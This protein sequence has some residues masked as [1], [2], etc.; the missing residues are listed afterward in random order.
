MAHATRAWETDGGAVLGRRF[1]AVA[2]AD[3]VPLPD[4]GLYLTVRIQ[5]VSGG[6]RVDVVVRGELDLATA[7]QLR[8]AAAGACRTEVRHIRG[9]VLALDL[10]DVTF[11]DSAGLHALADIH[12]QV[13]HRGWS[14]RVTP[15]AGRGPRRLLL[16]AAR[17]RWL[18]R[19]RTG[20]APTGSPTTQRRTLPPQKAAR[21]AGSSAPGCSGEKLLA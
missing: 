16:L 5:E 14:L 17:R 21:Y 12:A 1:P 4:V 9:V 10:T 20:L 7:P 6:T 8:V 13:V 11:M 19:W 3:A 2:V 18:P 15:P